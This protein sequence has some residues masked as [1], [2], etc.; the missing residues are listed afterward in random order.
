[1]NDE[2]SIFFEL[3]SGRVHALRWGRGEHLLIALHGFSDRA[4]L[5]SLLEKPWGERFTIVA[6]DLPFHGQT[7]WTAVSFS[8]EDMLGILAQVLKKE[9]KERFSLLGFSFGARLSLSMLP[10]LASQ[11]DHLFLLS[12][13]G[14]KTRGMRAAERTPVWL[15][16][17]FWRVLQNPAWLVS[18][19]GFGRKMGLVSTSTQAF[20]NKNLSRPERVRRMFGCWLAMDS[21]RI[22]R[23]EIQQIWKTMALPTRVYVGEKDPLLDYD[24]LKKWY[25]SLPNV[26]VYVLE[27]ESHAL[28]EG[29]VLA[30]ANRHS[31]D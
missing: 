23:Q 12:P 25:G 28:T 30:V 21:F 3:E 9:K 10:D 31:K 29:F 24:T 18:I 15:R 26:Q 19:L 27:N 2:R 20:L 8:K 1:M 16:Q 22:K 17:L 13:D 5:F 7:E 11:L 14:I 4:Q 6:L